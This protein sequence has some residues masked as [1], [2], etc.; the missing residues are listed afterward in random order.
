MKCNIGLATVLPLKV[1]IH[2]FFT[3]KIMA[4][5][6][7]FLLTKFEIKFPSHSKSKVN[8]KFLLATHSCTDH[9]Y[10]VLLP[11]TCASNLDPMTFFIYSL[12]SKY[13]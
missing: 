13:I 6:Y 3:K 12:I 8:F 2:F 9:P 1:K 5:T 7:H 11:I 10:Y 4:I